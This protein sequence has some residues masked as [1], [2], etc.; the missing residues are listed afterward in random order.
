M[1]KQ[2]KY[3]VVLG[4]SFF[5]IYIVLFILLTFL[6]IFIDSIMMND[7]WRVL[8][9]II[10]SAINLGNIMVGTFMLLISL[11]IAEMAKTIRSM[12]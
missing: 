3:D 10:M 4:L 6:T 8:L 9:L 1:N 5:F 11:K 12:Q 7:F 2:T